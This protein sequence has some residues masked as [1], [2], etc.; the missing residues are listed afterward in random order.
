M[1]A[2][3]G[4]AAFIKDYPDVLADDPDWMAKAR[5]IADHVRDPI[6]LIEDTKLPVTFPP[7]STRIAV[8]EPCTL[9][10]GLRLGGRIGRLLAGLGFEPQPVADSHLCCGSA[11]AY[12]L[13]QSAFAARLRADKIAALTATAPAVIVTAN[14]GCWLH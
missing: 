7:R 3:S 1:V 6:E 2:S 9:Q 5:R 13:T 12:S 8:Q 11:G 4:C 14:I 10:H